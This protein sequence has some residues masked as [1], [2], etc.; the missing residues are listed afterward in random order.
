MIKVELPEI[1]AGLRQLETK[2]KKN[3]SLGSV[4]NVSGLILFKCQCELI[5]SILRAMQIT[6]PKGLNQHGIVSEQLIHFQASCINT[7]LFP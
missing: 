2:K 7:T 4:R 1:T 6:P 3:R 5:I